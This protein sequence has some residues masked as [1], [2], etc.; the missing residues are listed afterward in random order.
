MKA[1]RESRTIALFSFNN[2]INKRT[3]LKIIFLHTICRKSDMF[4]P[5]HLALDGACV[6]NA[7][8]RPL[9]LGQ[10]PDTHYIGCWV[11][12]RTGLSGCGKCQPHR[13]SIPGENLN[14]D[15]TKKFQAQFY[16]TKTVNGAQT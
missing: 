3:N 4:L 7:T 9:N 15:K 6:V 1:M 2:K 8:P 16:H 14:N 11:G 12:P 13:D 5:S 10:R